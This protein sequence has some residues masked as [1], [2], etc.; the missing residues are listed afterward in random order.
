M[1]GLFTHNTSY[2]QAYKEAKQRFDQTFATVQTQYSSGVTEVS[3]YGSEFRK[4]DLATN[5]EGVKSH[6]DSRTQNLTIIEV[7][8][9]KRSEIK[10]HRHDRKEWIYV[11]E[12]EIE[13]ARSMKKYT[14][15]DC[16]VINHNVIHHIVS[17]KGALL[18]VVFSPKFEF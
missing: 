12:G 1:F 3:E 7:V 11:L 8:M 5:V 10:P 13:D 16:Y 18:F 17:C 15:G 9:G 2:R 4:V 6:L 14:T